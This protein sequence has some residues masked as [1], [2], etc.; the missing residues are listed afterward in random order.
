V[1]E[2]RSTEQRIADTQAALRREVDLWVPSASAA[3]EAYLAPLSFV[4]H[5]GQITLATTAASRT[6]RNLQRAGKARL[7]LGQLRDVIIVEGPLTFVPASAVAA[8]LADAFAAA[9]GFDPRRSDAEYVYIS[10]TPRR[11]QAWREENE[12]AGREIMRAGRWLI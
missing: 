4:W 6:A 7:A 1:P 8:D 9:A 12:L 10:L 11:M 3:G 5:N 2:P